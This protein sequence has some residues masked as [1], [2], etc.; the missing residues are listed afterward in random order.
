MINQEFFSCRNFS[1]EKFCIFNVY[2][3][4]MMHTFVL[5][6]SFASSSIENRITSVKILQFFD[7]LHFKNYQ[8]ELLT[9][10]TMAI[11]NVSSDSSMLLRESKP[12]SRVFINL[13]LFNF[14]RL[15]ICVVCVWKKAICYIDSIAI[16]VY[17]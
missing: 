15:M 1:R 10:S 11:S 17:S 8:K 4:K 16:F 9:T 5:F 7:N 14:R 2:F 6:L 13:S 3:E 12:I